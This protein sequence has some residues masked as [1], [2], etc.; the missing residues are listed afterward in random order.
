VGVGRTGVAVG[1]AAGVVQAISSA[2][3]NNMLE[4]VS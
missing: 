2:L 3:I 1:G 4:A